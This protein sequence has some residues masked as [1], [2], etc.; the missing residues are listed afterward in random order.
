M[1]RTREDQET[2]Y[3]IFWALKPE[4]ESGTKIIIVQGSNYCIKPRLD[5]WSLE[6]G[7]WR[8][9]AFLFVIYLN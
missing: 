6:P 5:Y 8:L 9:Q 7:A 3:N 1:I 4:A 2:A